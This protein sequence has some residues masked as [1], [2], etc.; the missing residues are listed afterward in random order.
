MFAV[1]REE[2][3][4]EG[5]FDKE[6]AYLPPD[7]HNQTTPPSSPGKPI[8]AGVLNA[9]IQAEEIYLVRN[10]GL[11][12]DDDI[13][14]PPNNV[15]SVNNPAADTLFEGQTWGWDG[16]DCSAMAAHNHNDPSFKN[17]QIPQSLS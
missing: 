5:L 6:P 13:A 2:G 3:P 14:P 11:E 7:I 12:V 17:V 8:E 4:S 16:I 15:P 9:Y 10:Q 1:V